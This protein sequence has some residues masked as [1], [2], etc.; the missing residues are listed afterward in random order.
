M[1]LYRGGGKAY[2]ARPVAR[3]AVIDLERITSASY[4]DVLLYHA[5]RMVKAVRN[6]ASA[7]WI[8]SAS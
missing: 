2:I 7:C 6:S 1:S 5:A 8:F 3:Q 4:L